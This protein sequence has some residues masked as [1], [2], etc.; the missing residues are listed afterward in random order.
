MAARIV[1][2]ALVRWT[3]PIVAYELEGSLVRLPLSHPLPYTRSR[4]PE[5]SLAVGEIA[6]SLHAR[7]DH[8]LRIVDVGANVGDTL[9]IIRSKAPTA[10][11][12]C[13]EGEPAF[14]NLLRQNADALG[15]V[16]IEETLVGP[17]YAEATM[18]AGRHGTASLVVGVGEH[19]T[20]ALP[21]VLMRHPGFERADL[22]KIDTDGYDIPI[23]I[24]AG[25]WLAERLPVLFFE[26]DLYLH[27]VVTGEMASPRVLDHLAEWGYHYLTVFSN[28]GE[29]VLSTGELKGG[30]LNDV[31]HY[32]SGRSDRRYC[33]IVAYAER[34]RD[35]WEQVRDQALASR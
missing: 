26:H 12:L 34:D 14:A 10:V 19:R 23:L 30:G 27:R 3:D 21:D 35:V 9:A 11:V 32:F 4:F 20:E 7:R 16:I 13:I 2:Y 18:A 15:P 33:D 29:H 25:R 22:V 6:G 5:Y 8:N 24:G 28:Q 1:R 31:L 17:G